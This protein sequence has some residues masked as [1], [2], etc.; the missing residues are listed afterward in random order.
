MT[1]D[2]YSINKLLSYNGVFNFVVGPRGNG[3]TYAAKKLVISKAIKNEHEFIYLRRYSSELKNIDNWFSDI[4]YEFPDYVFRVNGGRAQMKHIDDALDKKIPWKT[5]GYFVPLSKGQH[6]KSVPFPDVHW[7]IYDEFI[8]ETGS[9][10]YLPAEVKSF[11]DF[12]STVDR[13]QDRVRVLF[14]GNTLSVMNP[15]FLE[16]DIRP[17]EGVEFITRSD[18]FL[19]AQFTDSE[20]F[21]EGVYKTRFGKFIRESEYGD[22]SVEGVFVDN[23]DSMV[24]TK[25]SEYNYAYTI[26][27]KKGKFS[28]WFTKSFEQAHISEKIPPNQIEWVLDPSLMA[29]NRRLVTSSFTMISMVRG[30][31]SK[32]NVSFSSPQARNLFVELWRK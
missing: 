7:I 21:R 28:V 24:G 17:A 9:I 11:M 6:Y 31:F 15:Y 25:G 5:I 23:S 13:W 2:Y 27:S 32:G 18:N 3:K 19:V 12:Y 14:L 30:L 29:E 10:H 20:L 26:V 22:Y 8:I 4:A 1:R 16:F